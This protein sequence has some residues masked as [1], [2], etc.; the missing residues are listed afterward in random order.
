MIL[1]AYHPDNHVIGA[2]RRRDKRRTA[3]EPPA[4]VQTPSKD[5]GR[6]I[7][8]SNFE[9]RKFV[10]AGATSD[11]RALVSLICSRCLGDRVI[12]NMQGGYRRSDAPEVTAIEQMGHAALAESDDQLRGRRARHVEDDGRLAPEVQVELIEEVPVRGGEKVGRGV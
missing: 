7:G 9:S 6:W 2:I 10:L 4:P 8:C 11:I 12:A 1:R 3:S 5:E